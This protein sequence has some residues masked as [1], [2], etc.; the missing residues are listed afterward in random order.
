M[1]ASL[2]V[3]F[4]E[5]GIVSG[6]ELGRSA[7]EGQAG[8]T[9]RGR[10][11]PKIEVIGLR[12][13]TPSHTAVESATGVLAISPLGSLPCSPSPS[14]V[15]PIGVLVGSCALAC[16][17]RRSCTNRSH[18]AR[19]RLV[20]AEQVTD[21]RPSDMSLGD[22]GAWELVHGRTCDPA[23]RRQAGLGRRAPRG[24]HTRLAREHTPRLSHRC[25]VR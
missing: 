3:H 22:E 17:H 15:W 20:A 21:H 14:L 1:P 23:W 24:R 9:A 11:P 12:R 13:L 5:E 25:Q 18:K 8:R 7:K 19:V 4:L 16:R 10:L 6:G 2:T